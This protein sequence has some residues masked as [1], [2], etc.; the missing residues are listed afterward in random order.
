M[1]IIIVEDDFLQSDW[2]NS[3]IDES[4][5]TVEVEIIKTELDFKNKISEIENSPPQIVIMDIMVRWAFPGEK[6][7]PPPEIKK[8]SFYEA[9]IRCYRL[10]RSIENLKNVPVILYS[11]LSIEDVR[12]KIKNLQ[13]NCI[14]L[15]KVQND[16]FIIKEI[17]R[18]LYL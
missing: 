13:G 10:M 6:N 1:K 2:L 12:D 15:P 7:E 3:I 16:S 9:G 11:V 17:K 8:A 18:L 14:Y 4:F 5:P